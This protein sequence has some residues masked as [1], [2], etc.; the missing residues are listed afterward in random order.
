M[1]APLTV[2]PEAAR[3]T[4]KLGAAGGVRSQLQAHNLV[5]MPCVAGQ[6]YSSWIPAQDITYL[7]ADFGIFSHENHGISPRRIG[8]EVADLE[9]LKT[10]VEDMFGTQRWSNLQEICVYV[11]RSRCTQGHHHLFIFSTANQLTFVVICCEC[12]C[13]IWSVMNDALGTGVLCRWCEWHSF[14]CWW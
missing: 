12:F 6:M 14:W 13:Y 4:K 2:Q 11:R 7:K 8:G 3:A 5:F 10:S 9:A 1:F